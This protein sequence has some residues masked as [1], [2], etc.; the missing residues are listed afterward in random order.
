MSA[1]HLQE[2]CHLAWQD[3][4]RRLTQLGVS[5]DQGCQVL[6]RFALLGKEGRHPQN[7]ARGI[8]NMLGEPSVPGLV[9][10]KIHMKVERPR[11]AGQSVQ[12]VD[13]PLVAPH[14]YFSHLYHNCKERFAY[15]FYGPDSNEDNIE[16]FW[17]EVQERQDPRLEN[18]PILELDNWKRKVVPLS[19]HGD[20]VACVR[21]GRAGSKTFDALSYTGT[22]AY[23]AT[24]KTKLFITG[25]LHDCVAQRCPGNNYDSEE[26]LWGMIIWSFKALDS[27]KWPTADW[28]GA[29][30]PPDSLDAVR[31]NTD[32]ANG[33][34]AVIWC[35]KGDLDWYS[36]ALWLRNYNRDDACDFCEATVTNADLNMRALNFGRTCTWKHTLR[37]PA[38]WRATTS[39]MHFLFASLTYLS[40][41][42]VECDDLHVKFQGVYPHMFG[43]ILYLLI[44]H[45]MTGSVSDNLEECWRRILAE[46]KSLSIKTQ[47]NKLT[48][49]MFT[50]PAQPGNDWPMLNGRA[51][52]IKHLTKP[53]RNVWMNTA[54]RGNIFRHGVDVCMDMLCEM[55][56]ILDSTYRDVFLNI[57]E[58]ARYRRCVS[59]SLLEYVALAGLA[60]AE[61]RH[62][63]RKPLLF[64]TIIKLH[65]MWHAGYKSQYLHPTRSAC[66]SDEDYMHLVRD[67][68]Q[69]CVD[70][71]PSHLVPMRFVSRWRWSMHF[72]NKYDV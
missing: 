21:R 54:P 58:S 13:H 38:Q 50:N 64:D 15:L 69:S 55:Q 67:V 10:G 36:K 48:F 49:S 19:L 28:N 8:Q 31:A 66:W 51:A 71:T 25:W 4:E 63:P 2:L 43:S 29:E 47:I 24:S 20:G 27:G 6:K 34:R 70:G 62:D 39:V 5:L 41:W 45:C 18:H 57:D 14:E 17:T 33:M 53:L 72:M 42:N 35:I 12:E 61:R 30:F 7:I 65:W 60:D 23:G 56:D 26:E 52:E 1:P 40:I 32:L 68:V 3:E 22:L 16:H 44:F 59:T 11:D 37:S 9:I 46:H